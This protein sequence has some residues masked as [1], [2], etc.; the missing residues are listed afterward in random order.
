MP[1]RNLADEQN[2]S[3]GW[4]AGMLALAVAYVG[5][6]FL[7]AE[8]FQNVPSAG[9]ERTGFWYNTVAQL[10]NFPSVMTF[11]LQNRF[12]IIGTIIGAEVAVLIFWGVMRK[13]ERELWAK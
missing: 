2:K 6:G 1:N 7:A 12:W 8:Y 10:P 5:W 11:S 3:V 13:M 9:G 4:V